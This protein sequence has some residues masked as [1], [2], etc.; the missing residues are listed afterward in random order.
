MIGNSLVQKAKEERLV[1][2]FFHTKKGAAR[3]WRRR[4]SYLGSEALLGLLSLVKPVRRREWSLLG[5]PLV[6]FEDPLKKYGRHRSR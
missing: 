2:E 5:T 3:A 1:L 6:R 4:S